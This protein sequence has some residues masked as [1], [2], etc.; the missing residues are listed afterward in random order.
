MKEVC[1]MD[2]DFDEFV[3][4]FQKERIISEVQEIFNLFEKNCQI[5][6]CVG[7]CVVVNIKFEGDRYIDCQLEMYQ[8][9]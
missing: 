8:G 3:L 7:E 2:S 4:Y 6:G 9:I 1:N 5:K